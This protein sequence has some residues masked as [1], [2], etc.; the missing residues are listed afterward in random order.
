MVPVG[1]I[2]PPPVTGVI[3]NAV[4]EQI[5]FGVTAAITGVWLI[6]TLA[7]VVFLQPAWTIKYKSSPVLSVAFP[8]TT[9]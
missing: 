7:V 5:A 9:P 3:V 8:L 2:S 4:P 1:T 6:V